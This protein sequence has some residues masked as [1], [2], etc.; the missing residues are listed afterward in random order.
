MKYYGRSWIYFFQNYP[1]PKTK[2]SLLSRKSALLE[3]F[4]KGRVSM[5]GLS[6]WEYF[7]YGIDIYKMKDEMKAFVDKQ[8]HDFFE[9]EYHEIV[10]STINSKIREFAARYELVNGGRA[11][12]IILRLCQN[13][14]S[15]EEFLYWESV[16]DEADVWP[17]L[18][19]PEEVTEEFRINCSFKELCA[20]LEYTTRY[21]QHCIFGN[22]ASSKINKCIND[23]F[24]KITEHPEACPK[25][26]AEKVIGLENHYEFNPFDEKTCMP[27]FSLND[28]LRK[29][30]DFGKKRV[31]R[32]LIENLHCENPSQIFD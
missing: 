21:G 9:K 25:H 30:D 15:F 24:T 6:L 17:C 32:L 10:E 16:L 1:N 29:I 27:I 5:Y 11:T 22:E 20:Y 28:M 19:R 23:L 3:D 26:I 7:I 31:L 12:D 8:Y 2:E 13:Q 4:R 14:E 18:M